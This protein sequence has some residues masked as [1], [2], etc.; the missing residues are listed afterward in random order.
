MID[1]EIDVKELGDKIGEEAEKHYQKILMKSM[2]RMEELAIRNAPTYTGELRQKITVF[3]QVLSN[4]YFLESR[5]QH[6]YDVEFGNVPREVPLEDLKK[7]AIK[8]IGDDKIAYP[9]KLR[10]AKK[11]IHAQPFMRPALQAV[12][13][14]WIYVYA[15]E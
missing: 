6:S 4:E 14:Y 13:G 2:F 9:L 3:P 8:K 10:I 1:F 7:W 11:G 5:A 12:R 15:K